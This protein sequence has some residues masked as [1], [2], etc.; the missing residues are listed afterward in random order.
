MV[1][2]LLFQI[3]VPLSFLGSVYRE[4]RQALIDM[5][6]TYKIFLFLFMLIIVTG[7]VS[8]NDSIS[9]DFFYFTIT[10]INTITAIFRYFLLKC[11][12]SICIWSTNFKQFVLYCTFWTF[13]CHCWRFWIWEIHHHQITV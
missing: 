3:S 7:D 9:Q 8:N 12:L 5:Q 2:G 13:L 4:V 10:S 11:I 1:N 6:V